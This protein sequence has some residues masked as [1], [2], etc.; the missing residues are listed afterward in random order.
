MLVTSCLTPLPAPTSQ[1]QAAQTM[2]AGELPRAGAHPAVQAQWWPPSVFTQ[3]S[4]QLPSAGRG[5]AG[6]WRH[7]PVSLLH[8][9]LPQQHAFPHPCIAT[10][11]RQRRCE[12][13]SVHVQTVAPSAAINSLGRAALLVEHSLMSEQLVPSPVQLRRRG[14]GAAAQRG[15]GSAF[16]TALAVPCRRTWLGAAAGHAALS[17]MPALPALLQATRTWPL[18]LPSPAAGCWQLRQA[19]EA[20]LRRGSPRVALAGGGALRVH[21][22]GGVRVAGAGHRIT[23]IGWVAAPAIGGK[24]VP[25]GRGGR[26]ALQGNGIVQQ[27]SLALLPL[28][29]HGHP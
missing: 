6:T 24:R 13:S 11:S 8:S 20:A 21:G 22:A 10:P 2:P 7:D 15:R 19:P 29:Q 3:I 27:A 12:P 25:A 4:A 9:L 16:D 17:C 23:R 5:R 14:A 18:F 28:R 1:Q 26:G